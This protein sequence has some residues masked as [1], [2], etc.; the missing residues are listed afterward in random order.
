ME[1]NNISNIKKEL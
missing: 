1:F